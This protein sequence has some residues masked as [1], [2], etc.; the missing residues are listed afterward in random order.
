MRAWV[1]CSR[2]RSGAGLRVH[3]NWPWPVH[4]DA[5]ECEKDH[6][7]SKSIS[8]FISILLHFFCRVPGS[9]TIVHVID[10]CSLMRVELQGMYT[11]TYTHICN[12]ALPWRGSCTLWSQVCI[13]VS[14]LNFLT[15]KP[16]ARHFEWH[17]WDE[18]Y[19][20]Y[21]GI[22]YSIGPFPA[23]GTDVDDVLYLFVQKQNNISPFPLH[24]CL[25]VCLSCACACVCVRACACACCWRRSKMKTSPTLCTWRCSTVTLGGACW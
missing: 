5:G 1:Q 22:L 9:A 25:L 14:F 13:S 18:R 17:A 2:Q 10:F 7:W 16:T 19:I 20:I 15:P 12:N 11:C 23:H 6:A 24:R 4:G 21:L 3:P 8:S